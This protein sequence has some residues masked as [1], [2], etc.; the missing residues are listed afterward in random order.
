MA[1]RTTSEAK[2]EAFVKEK[3]FPF[4][5][6]TST[7]TS[8]ATATG[9]DVNDTILLSNSIASELATKNAY[10]LAV[11]AL[12]ELHGFSHHHT[13]NDHT[14]CDCD[15]TNY[16]TV[17]NTSVLTSSTDNNNQTIV[18]TNSPPNLDPFIPQKNGIYLGPFFKEVAGVTSPLATSDRPWFNKETNTINISLIPNVN[19]NVYATYYDPKGSVFSITE[20]NDHRY[21]KGNGI[22]N[23]PMGIF[24]VQVGTSAY[25]WYAALPGGTNPETGEDYSSAAAIPIS[26]YVLDLKITK[27]PKYNEIPQPINY[28]ILGVTFTG[29]VWHAEVANDA[30]NNWYNPISVLP[31]DECFGHP[32]EEQYHLH[33]YSWGCLVNETEKHDEQH[34]KH[35][36]EVHYK[37]SP[38]LGYALDGFG[39]YGPNDKDGNYISNEQ[40]DECHGLTS[41]V[42]WEG[43]LTNIYHYVLNYEYPY[44]IGAFRGTVDYDLVLGDTTRMTHGPGPHPH[45]H[46]GDSHSHDMPK[47]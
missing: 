29:T 36:G 14:I 28:L 21:F 35:G 5:T 27:Y 46:G 26:P 37:G 33:A 9:N 18:L 43:K 47:M 23:T 3:L 15:P 22:P 10:M 25:P 32:Y 24:P 6:A 7:A 20:D 12:H 39:I 8:S 19:G 13:T 17:T 45:P 42:M 41:E 40:L 16:E 31:M 2:A 44:S 11:N 34:L 1:F 30:S 4:S 38:L